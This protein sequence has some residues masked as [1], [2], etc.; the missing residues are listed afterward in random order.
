MGRVLALLSVAGLLSSCILPGVGFKP[1]SPDPVLW[2]DADRHDFGQVPGKETV[3][4]VF[5]VKNTGAQDLK[6]NRVQTSCGCTAAV[7]GN[8][9]LGSGE[10]TQLK[11]TFD[12]RGRTGNQARTVWIYSNDPKQPRKQLVIIAR[13][14]APAAPAQTPPA[15]SLPEPL[16]AR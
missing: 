13:I 8:Q 11:V 3:Q 7:L 2:V 5:A 16:P 15:P 1:T 4:H 12:P 10:T 14:E 6:I 9:I